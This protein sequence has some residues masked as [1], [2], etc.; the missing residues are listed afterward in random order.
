MWKGVKS[1]PVGV[2]IDDAAG[3]HGVF[4][5]QELVVGVDRVEKASADGLARAHGVMPIDGERERC[6][7]RN[8]FRRRLAQRR[9][10]KQGEYQ[11]K[12]ASKTH[13]VRLDVPGALCGGKGQLAGARRRQQRRGAGPRRCLPTEVLAG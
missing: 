8:C 7:R 3:D 6:A 4:G 5:Q 13:V 1:P 2:K 9:G 10:G 12:A 11:D